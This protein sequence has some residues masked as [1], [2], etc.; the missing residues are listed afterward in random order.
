MA[1]L[2]R[3]L[4]LLVMGA[5][6]PARAE[7][8]PP[9]NLDALFPDPSGRFQESAAAQDMRQT[10]RK[11]PKDLDGAIAYYENGN[12]QLQLPDPKTGKLDPRHIE[13]AWAHPYRCAGAKGAPV[14]VM[15]GINAGW[16]Q[17]TRKAL[18]EASE[19]TG[20]PVILVNNAT[21]GFLRDV[22]QSGFDRLGG[23][24][25]AMCKAV[26][27]SYL[28]ISGR[29]NPAVRSAKELMVHMSR[30]GQPVDWLVHSQ[31]GAI[32]GN[33]CWRAFRKLRRED[34]IDPTSIGHRVM[35]CG[36]AGRSFPAGLD[37]LH[38]AHDRDPISGFLGVGIGLL[39]RGKKGKNR[40]DIDFFDGAHHAFHPTRASG[41]FRRLV[42]LFTG[43]HK[44]KYHNFREIYLDR[45]GSE[46]NHKAFFAPRPQVKPTPARRT[47]FG[48]R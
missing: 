41:F 2:A 5:T 48:W 32:V 29:R 42:G 4:V 40:V 9:I 13:K 10:T 39:F 16:H 35:T 37:Q 20:R 31:A 23:N 30:K 21:N 44:V 26:G 34:H 27:L 8:P 3:F 15:T 12:F 25:F 45:L 36:G 28:P 17:N 38:L 24:L 11:S 43:Y 7:P 19:I 18:V 46:T 47:L 1:R 22:L 14:V 33:A 6:V